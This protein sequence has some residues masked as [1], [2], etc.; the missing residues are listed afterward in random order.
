MLL[1]KAGFWVVT[2]AKGNYYVT[3]GTEFEMRVAVS[4]LIPKFEVLSNA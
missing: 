2:A 4:K 3:L 1:C